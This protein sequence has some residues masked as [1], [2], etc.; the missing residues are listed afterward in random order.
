MIS[1]NNNRHT[2]IIA[3]H[4]EYRLVTLFEQETMTKRQGTAKIMG[5]TVQACRTFLMVLWMYR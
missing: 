5:I 4:S 3:I 2:T 1:S